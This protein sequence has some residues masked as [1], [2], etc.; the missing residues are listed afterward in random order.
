MILTSQS[1]KE[2]LVSDLSQSPYRWITRKE[3][4]RMLLKLSD[5]LED[6]GT[7]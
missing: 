6:D 4:D 3:M 2:L 7:V 5:H 1:G